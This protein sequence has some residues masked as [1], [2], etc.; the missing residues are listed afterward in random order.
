[1]AN[2][3]TEKLSAIKDY[4][5]ALKRLKELNIITNKRDF[6][7]QFGEWLIAEMYGATLATNGK[8]Q[9]WDMTLDGTKIQV[10]S[11]SKAITTT[12]KDTD[13][14][15]SDDAE[16]DILI[17]VIFSDTYKIKEIFEIP[18]KVA[19]ELKTKQTQEPVIKWNDIPQMYKVDIKEKCK[20]KELLLNFLE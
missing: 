12:R 9:Y 1:M 19:I 10:K 8:Q 2:L 17:I 15:Y 7:S 20:G 16:I 18:F 6:T 4:L 14:K 5:N 3:E 13:F 11:H